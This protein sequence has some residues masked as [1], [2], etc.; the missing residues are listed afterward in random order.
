MRRSFHIHKRPQ[1][2][3]LLYLFYELHLAGYFKTID[4]QLVQISAGRHDLAVVILAVPGYRLHAGAK[5]ARRQFAHQLTFKV[6]NGQVHGT[7]LSHAKG[8]ARLRVERVWIVLFQRVL[9]RI[10]GGHFDR[11]MQCNAS[12]IVHVSSL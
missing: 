11:S 4:P 8:D 6:E 10:A 1:T 12:V 5:I 9:F 2:R 7:S 3:P